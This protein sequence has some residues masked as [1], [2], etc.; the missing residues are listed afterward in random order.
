MA[1][2]TRVAAAREVQL[3]L[4]TFRLCVPTEPHETVTPDCKVSVPDYLP[5]NDLAGDP[6]VAQVIAAM[7]LGHGQVLVTVDLPDSGARR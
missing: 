3:M 7:Q 5:V 4:M 1:T 6:F 2:A